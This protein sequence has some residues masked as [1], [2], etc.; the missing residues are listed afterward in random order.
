MD[1]I[2]WF[3]SPH[4][5]GG[6]NMT[7]KSYQ[8]FLLTVSKIIFF[9]LVILVA[10]ML[11]VGAMQ[12]FWRYVLKSSLSW[13]EEILR[14]TNVWT[15]FLGISLAIPR[16][17]HTAIDAIYNIS[18][19]KLKITLEIIVKILSCVF[20]LLLIV[21]GTQFASFNATQ[22]SPTVRLPMVY[23][24][25]SIPIGGFFALL[26]NIGEFLKMKGGKDA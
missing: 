18:G 20:V 22:L 15:I 9:I 6:K 19:P 14:Y 4:L 1:S 3:P 16:G 11:T 26:F 24:Y 12:V 2:C 25:I 23:V 13:S 8:K 10:V 17:L 5:H 7:C 21:I